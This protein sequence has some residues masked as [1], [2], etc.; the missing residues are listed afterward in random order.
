M[1]NKKLATLTYKKRKIQIKL[2]K[3]ILKQKHISVSQLSMITGESASYISNMSIERPNARK[4]PL[5]D[6]HYP[7]PTSVDSETGE[8]TGGPIFIVNNEKCKDFIYQCNK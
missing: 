2:A 4:K 8:L 1:T 7:F 6:R 5:L 3:E